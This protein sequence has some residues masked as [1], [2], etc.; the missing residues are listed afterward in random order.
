MVLVV[1]P[2]QSDSIWTYRT[3]GSPGAHEEAS[4]GSLPSHILVFDCASVGAQDK[5]RRIIIYNTSAKSTPSSS[6]SFP[7]I[8]APNL[9][10][11]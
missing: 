1:G 3:W 5:G 4:M 11:N 7:P 8:K 9:A 6:P 10:E 2:S